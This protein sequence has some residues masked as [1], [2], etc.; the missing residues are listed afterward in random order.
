MKL[1]RSKYFNQ[2]ILGLS[3]KGTSDCVKSSKELIE[4]LSLEGQE[5]L[6]PCGDNWS[7]SVK[8]QRESTLQ[9]F[10]DAQKVAQNLFNKGNECVDSWFSTVNCY[11]D[12]MK[13][14]IDPV[15]SKLRYAINRHSTVFHKIL[16]YEKNANSCVNTILVDYK[17]KI[18]DEEKKGLECS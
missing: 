10:V 18:S 11:I 16:G 17:N 3:C 12:L 7:K 15:Q 5:A 2:I 13:N 8:T 6:K 4:K 14:Y 9:D 1:F